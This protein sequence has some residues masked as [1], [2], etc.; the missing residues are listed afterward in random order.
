MFHGGSMLTGAIGTVHL[1]F[2]DWVFLSG[3]FEFQVLPRVLSPY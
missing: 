1:G 3:D 2:N